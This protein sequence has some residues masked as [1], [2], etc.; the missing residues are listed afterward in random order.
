M[1]GKNPKSPNNS[2]RSQ[3]VTKVLLVNS[4]SETATAL[5]IGLEGYGFKVY[6]FANL[7]AA[8]RDIER[9][10]SVNYDMILCDIRACNN[11]YLLF[12]KQIRGLSQTV[13]IFLMCSSEIEDID[14]RNAIMAGIS[15]IIKKPI[16]I[17]NLNIV[18]QDYIDGIANPLD[19]AL[20]I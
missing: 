7:Y 10:S 3:G 15:E 14:I 5:K 17:E 11:E 2:L 8:T 18:L 12:V 16:S 9:T 1:I 4:D 19:S 6:H 13:K 20:K